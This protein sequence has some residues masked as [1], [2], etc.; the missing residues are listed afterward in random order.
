M[1]TGF[2]MNFCFLNLLFD[3]PQEGNLI[4]V[5]ETHKPEGWGF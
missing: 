5:V 1:R 2:D 3:L 4:F